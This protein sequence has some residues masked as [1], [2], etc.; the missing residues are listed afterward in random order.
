MTEMTSTTGPGAGKVLPSRRKARRRNP[1][2]EEI[3]NPDCKEKAP[4]DAPTAAE[5]VA[6]LY[7]ASCF[8]VTY[9]DLLAMGSEA[10]IQFPYPTSD[11]ASLPLSNLS[12]SG[13]HYFTDFITSAFH[14]NIKADQLGYML[15]RKMVGTPAPSVADGSKI[16]EFGNV[17]WLLLE[18]KT[19]TTENIKQIYRLNTADG[20]PPAICA[21]QLDTIQQDYA[22]EYWFYA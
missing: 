5:A 4:T 20:N 2:D 15:T 22:A 11:K 19:G 18:S 13:H 17:P 12:L 1:R 9:P 6:S 7:N 3:S 10:A 16:I 21:D 14:F 8:A